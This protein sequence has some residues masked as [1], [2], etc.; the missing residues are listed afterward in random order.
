MSKMKHSSGLIKD[1]NKFS[2]HP[3]IALLGQN[4]SHR[5]FVL[6]QASLRLHAARQRHDLHKRHSSRSIL[7]IH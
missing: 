4:M 5:F 3:Q 1:P 2:R 7:R 6:L